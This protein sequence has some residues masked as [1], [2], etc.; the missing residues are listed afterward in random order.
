MCRLLFLGCLAIVFVRCYGFQTTA[1]ATRRPYARP[2]SYPPSQEARR[3]GE[4]MLLNDTK[5][6]GTAQQRDYPARLAITNDGPTIL[7]SRTLFRVVLSSKYKGLIAYQ[8]GTYLPWYNW[9]SVY[10]NSSTEILSVDW[11]KS[12]GNKVCY[13]IASQFMQKSGKWE[14]VGRNQSVVQV[15]DY[16]LIKIHIK[17][18]N[19]VIKDSIIH[20]GTSL[21]TASLHDP[22]HYF[23]GSDIQYNWM[24]KD[25][26]PTVKTFKSTTEHTFLKEGL[27][28]I[29]NS[30]SVSKNGKTYT[31]EASL[32]LEVKAQLTGHISAWSIGNYHPKVPST[33]IN[34]PLGTVYFRFVV[35][36]PFAIFTSANLS[37]SWNFGDSTVVSNA[38]S[39]SHSYTFSG[40]TKVTL[41]VY[42]TVNGQNYHGVI[43]KNISIREP[44]EDLKVKIQP[45]MQKGVAVQFNITCK[46]S[47][48]VS[49]C[50]YVARGN[51]DL[52]SDVMCSPTKLYHNCKNIISHTFYTTGNYCLN[53]TAA[54][55]VS[56]AQTVLTVKV[57]DEG[58]HPVG[59]KQ[60]IILATLLSITCAFV[61]L[62]VLYLAV[63]RTLVRRRKRSLKRTEEATFDFRSSHFSSNHDDT[64]DIRCTD[65]DPRGLRMALCSLY[66]CRICQQ[67]E[68]T[69]PDHELEERRKVLEEDGVTTPKRKI[70]YYG[71]IH[72]TLGQ[73]QCRNFMFDF[74]EEAEEEE[75]L[76]S[77]KPGDNLSKSV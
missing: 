21:F 67:D 9:T 23:R 71:T 46:G 4:L 57:S 37:Y 34:F 69:D 6:N 7:G 31:G 10:S 19:K 15:T 26:T 65:I 38:T 48:P 70:S 24:F 11:W 51:C 45:K 22:S 12:A 59:R 41:N 29:Q 40:C 43:F 16:L 3:H 27:Y 62:F 30:V 1:S 5:L 14:I 25:G 74:K 72:R 63:K 50:W 36:D 58:T 54:N 75:N 8:W 13:F 76:S 39:P 35:K 32:Y 73:K 53:V 20:L 60:Q 44:I 17:Q 33:E 68:N 28:Y 2:T 52:P 66:C 18:S 49:F 77:W 56:S 47:S 64:T 55:T 61:L 42:A